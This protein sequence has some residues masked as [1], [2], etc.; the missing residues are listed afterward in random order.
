MLRK[1]PK[2]VFGILKTVNYKTFSIMNRRLLGNILI[3]VLLILIGSGVVMYFIPF[4]KSVASIHTFFALLFI[5]AMALH[6]VNNKLPLSNYVTGKRVTKFKKL[7][8]PFIFLIAIVFMIGLYF[9]MP[10]F[11][12]LYA[13]GNDLRNQQ[14]GKEETVFDYQI[15]DLDKAVGN[16]NISIEL[17]KGEAFQ[18]PLFAVWIEDLRGNYMQ[19]LY[20]SRVISSSTFDYGKNID[21]NWESAIVRRPE[22]LP[23]WSHKRGVKASD[24]L[25]APL[26]AT[27]LDAI[28]GATPTGNFIVNSKSDINEGDYRVLIELNQ[29]YD[30]NDYYTKDKFPNDV[31]YSGSGQVGQPS[32]IYS[33]EISSTDF[34]EKAHKIMK[35]IGHGHHS[36]KDGNLYN[37]LSHI[38]TAKQIADR[39]ILSIK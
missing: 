23:Y 32:L 16:K 34:N 31:I 17:K 8:S 12:K 39:I 33:A 6:L 22:A 10:V 38:T 1:L 24:G 19:T 4:K 35:L 5:L 26:N 27:D 7:Q 2:Q 15:I 9:N 29:S 3:T 13:F 37:D 14:L 18:Y 25:Y 11:N 21:G 36:G 20:I 30:W 28:S